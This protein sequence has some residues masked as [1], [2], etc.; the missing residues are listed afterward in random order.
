M[1]LEQAMNAAGAICAATWLPSVPR[2]VAM[3]IDGDP[4]TTTGGFENTF[5]RVCINGFSTA[6]GL[7]TLVKSGDQIDW[8][9]TTNGTRPNDPP[10][11]DCGTKEEQASFGTLFS[12]TPVK[13][14]RVQPRI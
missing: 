10:L 6:A 11:T 7:Q 1:S 13:R 3:I 5:W 2:Y 9:R 8:S 12:R 4:A 14:S